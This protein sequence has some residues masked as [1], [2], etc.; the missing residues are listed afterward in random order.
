MSLP[1]ARSTSYLTLWGISIKSSE[2][3]SEWVR[4]DAIHRPC[5]TANPNLQETAHL[6]VSCNAVQFQS[7]E[8]GS[9]PSCSCSSKV[10]ACFWDL[11][12][13]TVRGPELQVASDLIA[14]DTENKS[15]P[16]SSLWHY[17]LSLKWIN[18][19]AQH[20]SLFVSLFLFWV[21][22]CSVILL[23]LS[24]PNFLERSRCS[25]TASSV[26]R[27]FQSQCAI[28]TYHLTWQLPM[29]IL[30]TAQL[31]YCFDHTVVGINTLLYKYTSCRL[32]WL[33]TKEGHQISLPYPHCST[34]DQTLKI[35]PPN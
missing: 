33:L 1:Q 24:L 22:I 14:P 15:S 30:K 26:P 4:E 8:S 21:P 13:I 10:T 17:T 25:S 23:I 11:G 12:G 32:V 31:Q 20:L 3:V 19:L 9:L 2:W 7:H 28:N 27:Q 5:L 6:P 16:A 34:D 29:N 18:A 35:S